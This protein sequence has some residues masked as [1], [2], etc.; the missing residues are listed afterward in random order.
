MEKNYTLN[1]IDFQNDFVAPNGALTFDN[2]KGDPALIAKTTAFFKILPPDVFTNAIVTYDTHFKE[3]YSQS[4]EGKKFPIH[5]IKNTYGWQ[6]AIDKALIERKIENIQY[7]QK[8]TYD[9]WEESIEK[10]NPNILK[11]TKEVILIGVASDICNKAALEG[12]IKREIPVTILE[13][14]TRGIYKQT[15]EV[16]NQPPFKEAVQKGKIKCISSTAFLKKMQ[17]ERG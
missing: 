12:W 15:K 8:S 1:F 11:K 13:D 9:M 16:L 2:K 6:L 7:L 14:L 4:E 5:C 17:H 3:T 10:I